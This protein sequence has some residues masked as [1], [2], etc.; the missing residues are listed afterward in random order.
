MILAFAVIMAA[1]IVGV[2]AL[3]LT[4]PGDAHSKGDDQEWT[5]PANPPSGDEE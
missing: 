2:V 4:A 3:M 1:C 5:E